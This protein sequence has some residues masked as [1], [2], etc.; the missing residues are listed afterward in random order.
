MDVHPICN[1]PVMR[2]DADIAGDETIKGDW[3][4]RFISPGL[5]AFKALLASFR[6]D[7]LCSG[8]KLRLADI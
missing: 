3:M 5:T 1:L 4:Q 2:Y 8:S 7:P 6:Q